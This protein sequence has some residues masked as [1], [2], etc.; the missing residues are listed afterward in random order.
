MKSHMADK[1]IV[2]TIKWGPTYP[3][4]EFNTLFQAVSK[5]LDEPFSFVC[6]T[7]NPVGLHPDIIVI[8]LPEIPLDRDRWAPGM[9]PK[10]AVFKD[11]IFPDGKHVIFLDVDLAI[12]K[13]IAPFFQHLE[14]FGGLHL[15]RAWGRSWRKL[16]PLKFRKDI[17]GNSSVFA[18]VSGEQTHIYE[19]FLQDADAAL[20]SYGNDQLY[21]SRMAKNM[22]Y[23]PTGWVASFKK[24]CV[25]HPPLNFIFKKVL[26][27]KQSKIV[28]FHG[29]PDIRDLIKPGKERW[30][31]R[32][33]FG[34]GPVKWVQEYYHSLEAPS[35]DSAR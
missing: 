15:I 30:G 24:D 8:D 1:F 6:I 33:R 5:S 18:F 21:I 32:E 14:Q 25:Y 7:D 9:W 26:P 16:I 2:A 4:D 20:E 19:S 23:W 17:G 3:A 28:I 29:K 11:G 34:Y 10:L 22:S 35:D 12:I 31:T 27:P 13:P